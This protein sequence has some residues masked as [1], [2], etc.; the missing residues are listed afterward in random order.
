M[1]T[2]KLKSNKNVINNNMPNNKIIFCPLTKEYV[3]YPCHQYN[4][5]ELCEDDKPTTIEEVIEGIEL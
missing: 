5:C 4:I 1:L 3:D 2:Y